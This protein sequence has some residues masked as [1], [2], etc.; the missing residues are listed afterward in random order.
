MPE[1]APHD[2]V[3]R[4]YDAV[5]GEYAARF[6]E[7]LNSKPF[8]RAML[9]ALIEQ[10]EPGTTAADVGCGPAHV[11]AWLTAR[12][13]PSVG[14]DLSPATVEV[15][16]RLHPELDLRVGDFLDLPATVAE[17]GAVVAFYSIIHLEPGE[18]PPAFAEMRRVLR[19][20]GLLLVSFHVGSDVVHRDK[21]FGHDVDI[22]FRLLETATIVAEL[23][24]AGF[25]L[26]V[27]TE[28]AAY[29]DEVATQRAYLLWR[30]QP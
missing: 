20:G 23:T 18:R 7:E 1:T 12:G 24:D 3:R 13:L 17:F 8:D 4:S 15:A 26:V 25:D 21:W 19:P 27:S 28:R 2:R 29:E 30:R 9:A 22:D 16:G 10:T 6:N 14:I 5:A 11:A